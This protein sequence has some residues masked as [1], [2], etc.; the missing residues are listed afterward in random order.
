VVWVNDPTL[1]HF[2]FRRFLENRLRDTFG[3]FGTPIRVHFRAR[4][5]ETAPAG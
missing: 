3:F 1:V 5:K 4:A 2:G